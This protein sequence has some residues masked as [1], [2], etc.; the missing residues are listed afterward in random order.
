MDLTVSRALGPLTG[1]PW[2]GG[3]GWMLTFQAPPPTKDTGNGVCLEPG[4]GREAEVC[5]AC[6]TVTVHAFPRCWLQTR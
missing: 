6:A 4:N 5:C 1:R 2:K 3:E